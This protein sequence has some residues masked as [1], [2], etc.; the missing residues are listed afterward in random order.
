MK[1]IVSEEM[2]SLFP[3]LRIGVFVCSGIDN[4]QN[5][6][7]AI[8][9]YDG[10]ADRIRSTLDLA[11]LEA[12]PEVV[13]W[14]EAYELV[15][16]KP[17]RNRPS[18]ESALRGVLAS[19]ERRR[20]F[21]PLVEIYLAAQLRFRLSI[22]GY[23]LDRVQ[24]DIQLRRSPGGEPFFGIGADTSDPTKPG[25][26]VYADETRVLTRRWN[27]RDCDVA[28]ITDGSSDVVLMVEAPAASIPS[29]T[30]SSLL[31][32]LTEHVKDVCGGACSSGIWNGGDAA[33]AIR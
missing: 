15:G 16:H 12:L 10:E 2:R 9:L 19:A 7:R 5:V 22:G 26:V 29:T 23:D 1:L 8:A 13:A 24:G 17:K 4:R 28:K 21:S 14:R 3:A 18:A 6:E 27:W 31:A 11:A 20:P 32:F 25:E 33:F 30:L